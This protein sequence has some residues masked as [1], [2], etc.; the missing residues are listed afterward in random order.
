M[1]T[2]N[3]RCSELRAS[4]RHAC[5][6]VNHFIGRALTGLVSYVLPGRHACARARH[7]IR[8]AGLVRYVLPGGT[9]ERGHDL[10]ADMRVPTQSTL[11]R[12]RNLHVHEGA[13]YA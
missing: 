10:W 3:V 8:P 5:A 13:A 11:W 1:S 12:R 7:F 9:R 2:S 4:G 6:R